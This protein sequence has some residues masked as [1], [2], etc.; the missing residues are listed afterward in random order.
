MRQREVWLQTNCLPVF[1]NGS[2]EIAFP[3]KSGTYVDVRFRE[4]GIDTD[5]LPVL[6]YRSIQVTFDFQ[7]KTYLIVRLGVARPQ[8]ESLPVFSYGAVKVIL[9]HKRIASGHVRSAGIR[10][11]CRGR[12]AQEERQSYYAQFQKGLQGERF[13]ES[14]VDITMAAGQ[15]QQFH[16]K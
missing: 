9:G 4:S 3:L 16:R 6:G 7:G 13:Y 15:G 14:Q 5:R 12:N 10:C 11:G 2:V 8:T 1:C